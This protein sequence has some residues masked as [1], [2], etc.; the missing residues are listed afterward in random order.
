MKKRFIVALLSVVLC[1]FTFAMPV[2]ADTT[3]SQNTTIQNINTTTVKIPLTITS[4]TSNNSVHPDST[5]IGVLYASY[6][7]NTLYWRIDAPVHGF[8]G[9]ISLSDSTSGLLLGSWEAVGLSGQDGIH[10]SS[11]HSYFI[12]IVGSCLEGTLYGDGVLKV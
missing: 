8:F 6:S 3:P 4:S 10:L 1:L 7:S 2:L 12:T 9:T 11:G 5:I